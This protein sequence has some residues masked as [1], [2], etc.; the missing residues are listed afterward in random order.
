MNQRCDRIG[1]ILCLIDIVNFTP[2]S[3]KLE[4]YVQR[5]LEYYYAESKKIIQARSFEWIKSVG[6]A[7]LF[8]GDMKKIR[9][10]IEI[11]RDL[12]LH[13]KIEDKYGFKVNLRMVAHLG[14]FDF[15]I[16]EKG[17]KIDFTG[18]EAIRTFRMEKAANEEE[19]IITESL[20]NGID[21]LLSEYGIPHDPNPVPLSLKGFTD[22]S[23]SVYRLY[24]ARQIGAPENLNRRMEDLKNKVR[25][26][27]IFGGLYPAVDI[28]QSFINLS[29]DLE[30]AP[31]FRSLYRKQ[32]DYRR[33]EI[34]EEIYHEDKPQDIFTAK[35]MFHNFNKGFIYG[36][37]GSGKT[38]ILRYFVHQTF[39]KPDILPLYARCR[40]L[41]DFQKWCQD[42][43]YPPEVHEN[44]LKTGIEYLT[45]GF[46]FPDKKSEDLS[47]EE[48]NAL[49]EAEQQI[50]KAWR[51]SKLALYVDGLDEIPQS[52]RPTILS[53]I[54]LMMREITPQRGSAGNSNRVF[55]TSRPVDRRE[56]NEGQEPVFNVASLDS[57]QVRQ[58]AKIFWGEE[59]N[60]FREFSEVVWKQEVVKKVAGTP[61]TALLLIVYYEVFQKIDRRFPMYD[62]LMKFFLLRVWEQIKGG[63]LK[64]IADFFQMARRNDFE[65]TQPEA[66]DKYNCLSKLSYESLY[67]SQTGEPLRII[68]Y[69]TIEGFFQSWMYSKTPRDKLSETVKNWIMGLTQEQLLL[70]SGYNEYTILHSSIMEFLA[71]RWIIRSSINTID[72][73]KIVLKHVEYN[74]ET[75]PI[76]FSYNRNTGYDIILQ[77]K[78]RC[79][80]NDNR[81]LALCYR[82]LCEIEAIESEELDGLQIAS[83]YNERLEKISKEGSSKT[84]WLYQKFSQLLLSKDKSLLNEASGLFTGINKLSRDSLL[85]YIPPK[86][87]FNVSS[88]IKQERM[89]LIKN[90]MNNQLIDQWEKDYFQEEWE[91]PDTLLRLDTE[92]YHPEDKNFNYYSNVIGSELK[93]FFGSPNFKHSGAV[94]K[95]VFSPDGKTILSASID[96]TLKLWDAVSGKEI[97]SFQGHTDFVWSGVFSSDGKTV[98]SASDDNTL[99]LWDVGSGK[100]IRSF[101]ENPSSVWSGVF[102]PDG[103]TILS[104]SGDCTLKLWDAVSGKEIRSFQGHKSSVRSGIFSGDGKTI[105]SASIDKT[106]KLWDAVSGKE[107]RS[108][109]GHKSSVW[110]GVFSADGKTILSASG[111]NNLKLWDSVSG[112][113]IRS[114]QGHIAPVLSGVFSADGKT[115]LSASIDR[116]LKLWDSRSGEEIR[117]FERHTLSVLSG[118]FSGDGKTILSA[119]GDHTLKLWDA[120]SGREIHSFQGHTS[121][122]LSGVFSADGKTILSASR[123]KTLKLW[124]ASTGQCLKT[125]NLPWIPQKICPHPVD[126]SIFLTAN[127]NATLTLFQFR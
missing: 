37:P 80:I 67:E 4:G 22:Q 52:R 122:V 12:F 111:D 112:K 18:S 6:D 47:P 51:S 65:K 82:C 2:Q 58:L 93:G 79:D 83:L 90:L 36:I 60:L 102:S 20:Y 71:S 19:V 117:S 121:S 88:E 125:I 44:N 92:K 116:T 5:F 66:M 105:L 39:K 16:D 42:K 114:F 49:Q 118:V 27:P 104:A 99:K 38:T 62:L 126:P 59:S 77:I 43:N 30:R 40:D 23:V 107:I 85:H 84:Q 76:A 34:R 91:S 55:L 108:F 57:E 101:Q 56:F 25:T 21:P 46:L 119:S 95:A 14:Y 17:D 10:F 15:W 61:L 94:N 68:P 89:K 123:D 120:V 32:P 69:S 45:S 96:R 113:E 7:V 53:F 98:L 63:A 110:S 48:R 87:F 26:I 124:D 1:G 54:K 127:L 73:R 75:L 106:L 78:K 81:I 86:E 8:F 100:E 64:D 74:L 31:E 13:R 50:L 3:K 29:I 11:I 35:E 103:K 72:I 109:K 28:E 24:P 41:M 70:L 115:I 9:E 97:H 33:L